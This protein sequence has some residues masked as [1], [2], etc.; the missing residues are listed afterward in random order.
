[1]KLVEPLFSDLELQDLAM[2]ARAL[3]QTKRSDSMAQRGSSVASL[4]T[5]EAER[6]DRL[7]GKC[8]RIR[9]RGGGAARARPGSGHVCDRNGKSVEVTMDAPTC[10]VCHVPQV[11]D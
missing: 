11:F 5:A 6:L 3:A 8:E 7:A 4:A 9:K 10:S 1:M 2:S